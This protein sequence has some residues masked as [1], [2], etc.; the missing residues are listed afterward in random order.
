MDARPQAYSNPVLPDNRYAA[1]IS[2]VPGYPV[3]GGSVR[4][5]LTKFASVLVGIEEL[6]DFLLSLLIVG[7]GCQVECMASGFEGS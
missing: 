5:N 1:G 6:L 4:A 2:T 7:R 3:P